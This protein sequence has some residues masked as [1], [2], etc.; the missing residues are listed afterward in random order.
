[1]RPV[2]V[3]LRLNRPMVGDEWVVS[4]SDQPLRIGRRRSFM[5]MPSLSWKQGGSARREK[6]RAGVGGGRLPKSATLRRNPREYKAFGNE[7]GQP[8]WVGLVE[9][10]EAAGIEPA[11]AG[12]P[13]LAL[14]A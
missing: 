2:P 14:H 3:P 8:V 5:A 6:S 13:P 10:V 7:K 11:S 1:M 9:L 4:R 12:T